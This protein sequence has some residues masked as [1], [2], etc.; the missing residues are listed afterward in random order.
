MKRDSA[1]KENHAMLTFALSSLCFSASLLCI[2]AAM[3]IILAL[4][5]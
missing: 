3:K 5:R 4:A 1:E 2:A